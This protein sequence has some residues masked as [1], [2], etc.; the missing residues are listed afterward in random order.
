MKISIEQTLNHAYGTAY[1]VV[2]ELDEHDPPDWNASLSCWFLHCPGQS[3]AW[4]CYLFDIIHLREIEGVAPPTIDV[5]GATHQVLLVALNP[6]LGPNPLEPDTW[7]L[8]IPINVAEQI[9]LPDDDAARQVGEHCVKAV[10]TG[11]MPAEPPLAGAVEPWRTAL[12]K[13]AAH[14]RGEEHAP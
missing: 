10:L 9:I 2:R 4:D 3:P 13:T 12:A 14:A 5:P 8:L 11:L 1:R 6:H 7:Q